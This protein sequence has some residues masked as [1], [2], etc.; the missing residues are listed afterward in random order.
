[1]D[2]LDLHGLDAFREKQRCA[3]KAAF[4]DSIVQPP[5]P[6]LERRRS[7]SPRKLP[8]GLAA[9]DLFSYD[10][11]G[12][13]ALRVLNQLT[14]H[15]TGSIGVLR[16]TRAKYEEMAAADLCS[17]GVRHE[18]SLR[19]HLLQGYLD[20]LEMFAKRGCDDVALYQKTNL[21]TDPRHASAG[22][23]HAFE[24]LNWAPMQTY[25]KK[26]RN[27]LEMF[28]A[29]MDEQR[30][31]VNFG[32]DDHL[33]NQKGAVGPTSAAH[34]VNMVE[35]GDGPQLAT[36][37]GQGPKKGQLTKYAFAAANYAK[38]H[39]CARVYFLNC[40]I[41]RG[42]VPNF[43][44]AVQKVAKR[45]DVPMYYDQVNDWEDSS[46]PTDAS[47]IIDAVDRTVAW[48]HS[49]TSRALV[50]Y[51]CHAGMDRSGIVNALTQL[52]VHASSQDPSKFEFN[53]IKN[54][55]DG[56]PFA[57]ASIRRVDYVMQLDRLMR[58]RELDLE[59]DQPDETKR[60]TSETA[61]P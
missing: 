43:G 47:P 61:S 6:A 21:P 8:S 23:F 22:I 41:D 44:R 26:C 28:N 53:V 56:R 10:H 49:E 27:A 11:E 57:F 60:G 19:N 35:T 34:F 37:Q 20:G 3:K 1:M 42:Q 12:E 36:L 55:R 38:Q 58:L 29:H 25:F 15:A 59:K 46:L 4:I 24:A 40:A 17:P 31:F 30:Y 32:T 33:V 13:N 14:Q 18:A 2:A 7:S 51:N 39:R 52:R 9:L 54:I 48:V 45:A 5:D 50:V 16:Q